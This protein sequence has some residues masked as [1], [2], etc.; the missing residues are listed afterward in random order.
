LNHLSLLLPL[1]I[2]FSHVPF[3]RR[4][5]TILTE[6]VISA[7]LLS[8]SQMTTA[9]LNRLPD[10][11]F[12]INPQIVCSFAETSELFR[13]SRNSIPPSANRSTSTIPNINCG[14]MASDVHDRFS[15][16]F[17]ELERWI[18]SFHILRIINT[19]IAKPQIH[20]HLQERFYRRDSKR[21]SVLQSPPR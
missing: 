9:V 13:V 4:Q 10:V 6:T 14:W 1:Y 19:S 8:A 21:D 2:L 16:C 15:L 11:A 3:S 7:A 5:M 18:Q 12:H 17:S 20:R